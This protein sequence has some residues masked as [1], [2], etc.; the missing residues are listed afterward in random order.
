MPGRRLWTVLPLGA[1]LAAL[2][3]GCGSG[4]QA[5]YTAKGSV[6]CLTAKGFT[7]A[8]TD[9]LKVGFIAGV[10]ENGGI[11]AVAPS[12]NTLTIAFAKDAPDAAATEKAFRARASPFYRRHMGDIMESQ[13]NAVLVWTTAPSQGLLSTA[14]GCLAP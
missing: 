5:A 10:A 11:L 12:G 3:A 14:L 2:A 13:R 7:H 9:P 1:A 4:G 8:T 6:K